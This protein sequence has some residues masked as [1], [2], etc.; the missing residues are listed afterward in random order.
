MLEFYALFNCMRASEPSAHHV[1][2]QSCISMLTP[3]CSGA[4]RRCS[5]GERQPRRFSCV[6]LPYFYLFFI[7][8]RIICDPLFT[9]AIVVFFF[10]VPSR[11]FI[12]GFVC[13]FA[14]YQA[15]QVLPD[16]ASLGPN[17]TGKTCAGVM[18]TGEGL[19]GWK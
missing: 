6:W 11:S 7:V 15:L 12:R 14:S 17:M 1:F 5:R 3:C 16:P 13:N 2:C 8:I 4:P 9:R 18:C 19:Q 10:L